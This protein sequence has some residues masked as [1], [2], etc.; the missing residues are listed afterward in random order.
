G[1]RTYVCSRSLFISLLEIRSPTLKMVVA[2]PATRSSSTSRCRSEAMTKPS[3]FTSAAPV[4]SGVL[5]RLLRMFRIFST[6]ESG[7]DMEQT[8]SFQADGDF[9]SPLAVRIAFGFFSRDLAL[10]E[11]L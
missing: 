7:A 3:E 10:Q 5:L 6:R 1:V 4:I 11:C 2:I 8:L 9:A